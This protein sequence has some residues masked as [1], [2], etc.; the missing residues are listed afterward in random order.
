MNRYK[1]FLILLAVQFLGF[2]ACSFGTTQWYGGQGKPANETAIIESGPYTN[3]EAI[4]GKAVTGL[5]IAVLP[6]T[7]Q[8]SIKPGEPDQQPLGPYL[9][10][11]RVI[12]SISFNAEAG[13]T[14]MVYVNFLT[15]KKPADEIKGSG[16]VW[17]AYVVD[18]SAGKRI[19]QTDP[20][21]LEAEH[22][23]WPTGVSIPSNIYV[24]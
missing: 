3:I 23:G 15:E 4:D 19:A 7:Y 11:S 17:V 8:V 1:L 16:F 20:L 5:K 24:P 9:F 22:R 13:H 14:Y 10:F 2:T 21:P 12:G 18:Q 6:G